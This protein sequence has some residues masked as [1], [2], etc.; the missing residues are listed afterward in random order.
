MPWATDLSLQASLLYVYNGND[1]I[2]LLHSRASAYLVEDL[3][4]NP[5]TACFHAHFMHILWQQ[6]SHCSDFWLHGPLSL[7]FS[8]I[9]RSSSKHNSQ[10]L[11]QMYLR[12]TGH[13]PLLTYLPSYIWW[14]LYDNLQTQQA[15]SSAGSL[16]LHAMLERLPAKS[17]GRPSSQLWALHVTIYVRFFFY[18]FF[19]QTNKKILKLRKPF[20][21]PSFPPVTSPSWN[22]M[23]YS[24]LAMDKTKIFPTLMELAV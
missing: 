7:S 20:L 13:P 21:A 6:R 10:G 4:W 24:A 15:W 17:V 1:T 14:L 11:A 23:K 18:L 5:K 19:L 22:T 2:S 9:I 16:C 3:R 8:I 12:G